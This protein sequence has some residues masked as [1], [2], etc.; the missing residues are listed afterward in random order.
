MIRLFLFFWGFCL[1]FSSCG[2]CESCEGAAGEIYLT[3]LDMDN[4]PISGVIVGPHVYA[5]GITSRSFLTQTLKTDEK[6]QVHTTY[7]FPVDSYTD[8]TLAVKDINDLKAVNYIKS[9]YNYTP[10]N[11]KITT[12]DTIRMDVLKPLTVRIKSNKPNIQNFYLNVSMTDYPIQ[13]KINRNF[14][15]QSP[16]ISS[17]IPLDTTIQI[18]AAYAKAELNITAGL[19]FANQTLNVYQTKSL[20]NYARRDTV[21]LFEF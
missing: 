4:K 16:K 14:Y 15:S 21:F 9:P 2:E 5:N 11:K 13:T 19:Q 17:G 18:P 20:G 1:L 7:V 12:I 3:V 8:W 10:K 6:G